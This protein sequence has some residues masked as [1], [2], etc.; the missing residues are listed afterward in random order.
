[1]ALFMLLCVVAVIFEIA[2][3][4][5]E[6]AEADTHEKQIKLIEKQRLF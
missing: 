5:D 4:I 1:M 6:W 2:T 3:T